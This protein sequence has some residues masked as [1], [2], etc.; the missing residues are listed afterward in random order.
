MLLKD[1]LITLV[2]IGLCVF[3]ITGA[4]YSLNKEYNEESINLSVIEK[5]NSIDKMQET[6]ENLYNTI[7][8]GSITPGGLTGVIFSGIGA[9]FQIILNVAILPF[10]WII[11][12]AAELGIPV[13]ISAAIIIILMISI[14]TAVISAIL[15]KTP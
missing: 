3:A 6:S 7:K 15:R 12:I 14:T 13:Q 1:Y 2:L 11:T 9:F 10:E 4:I 5:M 8:G